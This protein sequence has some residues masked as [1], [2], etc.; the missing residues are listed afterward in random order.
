MEKN[1]SIHTLEF[2][3]SNMESMDEYEIYSLH[4]FA[5]KHNKFII[6]TNIRDYI[7]NTCSVQLCQQLDLPCNETYRYQPSCVRPSLLH[8]KALYD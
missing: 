5:R 6:L 1:L 3:A 8:Y 2:F 7:S 4:E